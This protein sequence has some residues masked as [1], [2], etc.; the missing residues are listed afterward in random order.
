MRITY[1]DIM[2]M[3]LFDSTNPR[4]KDRSKRINTEIYE[5]YIYVCILYVYVFK[6]TLISECI[7]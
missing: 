5:V 3:I 4:S 1:D 6:Q 2:M 7:C